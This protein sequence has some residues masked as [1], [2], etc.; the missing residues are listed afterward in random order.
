[1]TTY[2]TDSSAIS[3]GALFVQ[4]LL[5]TGLTWIVWVL[6]IEHELG[7]PYF[8]MVTLIFFPL[9][10]LCP[11]STRPW[12]QLSWFLCELFIF[13]SLLDAVFTLGLIFIFFLL[14]N[15]TLNRWIKAG[16]L[17]VL[18][19]VL[20]LCR[21]EIL[22]SPFSPH[23]LVTTAGILMFRSILFYYETGHFNDENTWISKLNYFL[24]PPNIVFP[25]FPIVDY[26][27]FTKSFYNTH[28][29]NIY[30]RGINLI[31]WSVT[32]LLIY[33]GIY[34]FFMPDIM[35]L[36]NILDV[37]WYMVATYLTVIRLIGILSL[38]VGVLRLF[39]YN[40]PEI[41]NSIFLATSFSDI[42]RR[43]NLYW[44]DFILKIG[45]YPLYFYLRKKKVN[46]LILWSLISAFI[47][48]WFF[49][50]Y[51]WAWI[52]GHDPVRWTG[53]TY[54]GVF[55]ALAI[56]GSMQEMKKQGVPAHTFKNSL[57][58]S[59]KMVSVFAGMSVLYT[60]WVH[61]T[62]DS[63]WRYFIIAGN[64]T[65]LEWLLWLSIIVLV[66]LVAAIVHY[67]LHGQSDSL[68][69][70]IEHPKVKYAYFL[71]PFLVL[72]SFFLGRTTQSNIKL[73]VANE[74]L[75]K[76][77]T[78]QQS[79]GY[80][81]SILRAD[82]SS[83]LWD[84]DI[85]LALLKRKQFVMHLFNQVFDKVKAGNEQ[86]ERVGIH[87]TSNLYQNDPFI[88]KRFKANFRGKYKGKPLRTNDM[89]LR[90]TIYSRARIPGTIRIA[91]IGGSPDMG[92]GVDNH[93]FYEY[94]VEKELNEQFK[95]SIEIINFSFPNQGLLAK[96]YNLEYLVKDF[97]PDYC[98]VT[99]SIQ[100]EDKENDRLDEII[101]RTGRVFKSLQDELDRIHITSDEIKA[102]QMSDEQYEHIYTWAFHRIISV[103]NQNHIRP[104]I[105]GVP[106]PK[107]PFTNDSYLSMIKN[108]GF[109]YINLD[110]AFDGKTPDQVMRSPKDSHPSVLGH[111]LLADALEKELIRFL[112]LK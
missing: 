33:R 21:F 109:D 88:S 2:P 92:Y 63:W 46:H 41:F 39:G 66:I 19:I 3:R 84:D 62:F 69:G 6:N 25:L 16:A 78:R 77:D 99:R 10:A 87:E 36:K 53:V 64:S 28:A 82:I 12:I 98:F 5:L 93:E 105:L 13:L 49:H 83:K 106:V 91:L 23:V 60:L 70:L 48:T 111:R 45:Y 108:E 80:Y 9:H 102:R 17:L 112:H 67:V 86:D 32:C 110:H 90:D 59:G 24:L 34:Y 97:N 68:K 27:K 104:V 79:Q 38:S 8:F 72:I 101:M 40:L 7:L 107:K 56:W 65:W 31:L 95:D 14:L 26:Q 51:Q 73:Y 96:V 42:F 74:K 18:S 52:L 44:K 89:G 37:S 15:S 100:D 94:L 71:I 4:F 81:E 75:N 29:I 30:Q 22:N 85:D 47:L 20:F 50:V 1:M 58:T 103:C 55:G 11:I 54:W 57:I 61:A 76:N 43:I 35:R